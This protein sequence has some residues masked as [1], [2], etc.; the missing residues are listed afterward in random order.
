M[1]K[2][3]IFADVFAT[4]GMHGQPDGGDNMYG[5]NDSYSMIARRDVDADGIQCYVKNDSPWPYEGSVTITKI[6]LVT[7]VETTIPHDFGGSLPAGPGAS[8]FFM[9]HGVSINAAIEVLRVVTNHHHAV[10]AVQTSDGASKMQLSVV[11]PPSL[12]DNLLLFGPPKSL[13]LPK[14]VV[15]ASINATATPSSPANIVLEVGLKEGKTALYV[16]LTCAALGRFN[17]NVFLLTE[18]ISPVHIEFIPFQPTRDYRNGNETMVALLS[19]TLRV[20]HM[21]LYK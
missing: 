7:G 13:S 9:L 5:R 4:C 12:S 14:A 11:P 3:S 20:E 18:S 2:Q 10:E 17:D 8:A 6:N 15:T 21:A 1:Y 16:T 19:R